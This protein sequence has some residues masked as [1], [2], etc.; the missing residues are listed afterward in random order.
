MRKKY[1]LFLLIL[2]LPF[3]KIGLDTLAKKHAF[4]LA[5]NESIIK[6]AMNNHVTYGYHG[7]NGISIFEYPFVIFE[8]I[9]LNKEW[10]ATTPKG[11]KFFP[12]LKECWGSLTVPDNCPELADDIERKIVMSQGEMVRIVYQIH[13]PTNVDHDFLSVLMG[14]F[15]INSARYYF[16]DK[17]LIEFDRD[18]Q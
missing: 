1:W 11:V 2:S 3:L 8:I 10:N 13:A 4:Y 18:I 17:Y 16:S 12:K 6:S 14:E 9:R 15:D 5:E 7:E